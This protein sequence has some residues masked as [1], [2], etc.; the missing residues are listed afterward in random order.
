MTNASTLSTTIFLAEFPILLNVA[1][2]N[3]TSSLRK[4]II[5]AISCAWSPM[6]SMSVI[7]FK[8]DDIVLR[9]LATGCWCNK[10]LRHMDS[11]DL[12]ILSI[13]L[14]KG[15]TLLTRCLLPSSRARVTTS[16]TSSHSEPISISALFKSESCS[17]NLFL[18]LP[19]PPQ[20]TLTKTPCYVVFCSFVFWL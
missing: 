8:A 4:P 9:S 5:S 14:S 11:I 12:S 6:R 15:S 16:I 20:K 10:S 3:R 7:I 1:P 19:G 18:I 13:S 2:P 17:S